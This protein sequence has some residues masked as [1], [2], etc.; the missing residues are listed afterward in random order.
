MF[1]YFFFSTTNYTNYT[2]LF[3][4][5]DSRDSCLFSF[6]TTYSFFLFFEHELH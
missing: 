5:F 1:L 3:Y 2:N 6:L 4:S